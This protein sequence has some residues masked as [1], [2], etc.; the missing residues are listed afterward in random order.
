[1]FPTIALEFRK[2]IFSHGQS[3][4]GEKDDQPRPTLSPQSRSWDSTFT[5]SANSLFCE[6]LVSHVVAQVEVADKIELPQPS[7]F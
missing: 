5:E 2:E 4:S 6:S 3:P 1:M 7:G